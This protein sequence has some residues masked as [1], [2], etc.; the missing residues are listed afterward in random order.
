MRHEQIIRARRNAG[1]KV[2][3][4]SE[5][6][7]IKATRIVDI[8]LGSVKPTGNELL[9]IAEALNTTIADILDLPVRKIRLETK[10]LYW[11]PPKAPR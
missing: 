8:E 11:D 7:N 2:P 4:L 9:A 10:E 6:A 5:L 3:E 1:L